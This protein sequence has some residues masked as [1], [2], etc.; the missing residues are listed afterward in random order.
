M[1]GDLRM[2][3]HKFPEGRGDG[4]GDGGGGIRTS[5]S[6]Q[7]VLD[8]LGDCGVIELLL[9]WLQS[10]ELLLGLGT[11]NSHFYNLVVDDKYD[12]AVWRWRCGSD[13]C[14]LPDPDSVHIL[15]IDF[16]LASSARAQ[17]WRE[18]CHMLS[19]ALQLD[20]ELSVEEL[21]YCGQSLVSQQ[22]HP[23]RSCVGM[24][25]KKSWDPDVSF[26]I[27]KGGF[28]SGVIRWSIHVLNFSDELRVGVTDDRKALLNM[29]T[30]GYGLSF[31]S[32]HLWC[33][34]DG[35]STKWPYAA[36]RRLDIMPPT[37]G[38]HDL[39]WP[40]RYNSTICKP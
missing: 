12:A 14:R 39:A 34:S 9:P 16:Q 19:V 3:C 30:D 4:N 7:T 32:K 1:L 5:L 6:L 40:N 36:G 38:V 26:A 35:S 22:P 28:T 10:F 21:D 24:C 33:Y 23:A 17:S 8:V 31:N 13:A 25:T 15:P 18:A 37:W 11:S 20:A 29:N 27:S 2:A